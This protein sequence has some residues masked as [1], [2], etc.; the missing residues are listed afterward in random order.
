MA[1][2][3]RFPDPSL[4]RFVVIGCVVLDWDGLSI[5]EELGLRS[6]APARAGIGTYTPWAREQS[7]DLTVRA[8][9]WGSHNHKVGNWW[10][11][12]FGDHHSLPRPAIPDLAWNFSRDGV[13]PKLP[14][15]VRSMLARG[16]RATLERTTALMARILV[17][18]DDG[19]LTEAELKSAI[20][21][22]SDTADDLDAAVSQLLSMQY[23]GRD[24]DRLRLRI[25][26]LSVAKDGPMLA[27]A[28]SHG[29]TIMA[30]WLRENHAA[31]RRDLSGLTAVRA[32]V[33][34]EQL[35]TEIWH[36]VFGWTNY[37]LSRAGWLADPYG[38]RSLH[39]G[40]VPFVWEAAL[41]LNG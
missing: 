23:V 19:P 39:N 21:P 3:E 13:N 29:R 2:S 1:A 16:A 20:G 38:P 24:G 27:V 8:L 31:L 22:D 37:H 28:R 7:P 6:P 12:T 17:R 26:V 4:L 41:K 15:P 30:R 36:D 32:G 10:F 5:T 25:P 35:F 34:F 11:S 9:Y 18:L 33:P 40:F 14:S